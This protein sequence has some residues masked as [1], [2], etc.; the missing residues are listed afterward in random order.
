[1]KILAL[2]REKPGRSAGDF[3]PLLLAEAEQAWQ[4][5]RQGIFRELYFDERQ[6]TAVII[7]ESESIARAQAVLAT[8]PLVQAGLIEF[9]IIPLAPYDGFERMF[10]NKI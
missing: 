3:Q 2:E 7:L 8:L 10:E 4:L 5:Y 1:M 6:H 9:E